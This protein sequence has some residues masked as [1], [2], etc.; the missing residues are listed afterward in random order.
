VEQLEGTLQLVARDAKIQVEFNPDVVQRYRLIG[1]ENRDVQDERFRDDSVDAGAVGAGHSVTALYE[2]R[3][4]PDAAGELATVRIRYHRPDN[5]A[6]IEER[7]A[8]SSDAA[9][10]SFGDASARF[11]LG[12]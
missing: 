9:R 12:E 7:G 4:Y 2:I 5:T 3:R 6:V 11:C 8:A 10:R 1:Y